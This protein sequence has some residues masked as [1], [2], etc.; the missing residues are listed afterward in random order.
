MSSDDRSSKFSLG[1]V[2]GVIGGALAA[3]FL[4][5]TTGEENRKKAVET[6]NKIKKLAQEGELDEKVHEIFGDVTEEGKRLLAESKKELLVRVEELK[7]Q[8][9]SFDQA[10]FTKFVDET[11]NAV[12]EKVKAGTVYAEKLKKSLVAK[13]ETE[14][15]KTEKAKK[16]LKPKIKVEK[17]EEKMV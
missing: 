1:L 3:F 7:G 5:P 14:E 15:K 17:V 2:L 12:N 8:V 10:K 9:E 11:V 4:T 6:F 16:V 13:W